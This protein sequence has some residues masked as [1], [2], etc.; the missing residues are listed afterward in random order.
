MFLMIE[1]DDKGFVDDCVVSLKRCDAVPDEKIMGN[2][3]DDVFCDE[4][5]VVQCM[6]VDVWRKMFLMMFSGIVSSLRGCVG[7]YKLDKGSLELINMG[8]QTLVAPGTFPIGC[9]SMI[10]TSHFFE[11]EEEYD[12]RTGCLIKF[13]TLAE[14]HNELLQTKLNHLRELHPNVIIIYADYYNAAI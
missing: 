14:Y 5:E 7:K 6:A 8:A 1:E 11:K 4:L 3:S 12:N 13:N 2:V 9:S 10:L